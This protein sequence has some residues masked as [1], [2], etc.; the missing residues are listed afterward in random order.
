MQQDKL[1]EKRVDFGDKGLHYSNKSPLAGDD[2]Y[3][4]TLVWPIFSVN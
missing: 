1:Q 4:V 2:T 3:F